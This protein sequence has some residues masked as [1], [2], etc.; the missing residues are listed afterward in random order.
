MCVGVHFHVRA[1]MQCMCMFMFVCVNVRVCQLERLS[2]I[3]FT[4]SEL[5]ERKA[6]IKL[7]HR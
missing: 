5:V 1:H 4:L 6:V 3:T 7:A 2:S